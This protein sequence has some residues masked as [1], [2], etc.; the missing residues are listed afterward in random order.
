MEDRSSSE[1]R[2]DHGEQA[3]DLV[4]VPLIDQV[5][6]GLARTSVWNMGDGKMAA[7]QTRARGPASGNVSLSLPSALPN[8]GCWNG[9]DTHQPRS[10]G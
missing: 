3:A 7:L 5:R 1:E 10:G 9:R 6:Q 2:A 8:R 4:S